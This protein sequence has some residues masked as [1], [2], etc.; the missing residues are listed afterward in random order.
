MKLGQSNSLDERAVVKGGVERALDAT[1]D[2]QTVNVVD[3]ARHFVAK[4]ARQN[5][6]DVKAFTGKG[7][8]HELRLLLSEI[9]DVEQYM[10]DLVT[11][12]KAVPGHAMVL[13]L[14]P[15]LPTG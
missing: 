12:C 13:T 15:P 4:Q 11:A 9:D 7:K 5:R 1:E 6:A 8:H 14:P 3:W 10:R 2:Q